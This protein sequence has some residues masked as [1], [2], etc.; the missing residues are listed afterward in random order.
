MLPQVFQGL[1]HFVYTNSLPEMA[2]WPEERTMAERLLAAAD[3]WFHM[4][5][6]KLVCAEVLSSDMSWVVYFDLVIQVP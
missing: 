6:P 5:E 2:T 3:R 4:H 1:L